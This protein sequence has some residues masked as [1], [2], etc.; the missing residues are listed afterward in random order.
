MTVNLAVGFVTPPYGINLFVASAI[1]GEPIESISKNL[2]YILLVMIGC[3]LL[4]TYVPWIS[5]GLVNL[6]HK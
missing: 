3:V 4:F 5:M 2:L 1:S 6:L